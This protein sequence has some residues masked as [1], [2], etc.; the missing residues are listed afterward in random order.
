MKNKNYHEHASLLRELT[1]NKGLVMFSLEAYWYFKVQHF[2]H[3]SSVPL[4]KSTLSFY[5][6]KR[7][8]NVK[9]ITDVSLRAARR[10]E[11]RFQDWSVFLR[12]ITQLMQTWLLHNRKECT[13]HLVR[14]GLGSSQI[15]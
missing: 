2:V 10:V 1:G 4:Q 6:L 8:H 12:P 5:N 9:Y 7:D 14:E 15:E 11:V 13:K 3:Q